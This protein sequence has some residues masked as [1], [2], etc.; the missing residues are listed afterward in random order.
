MLILTLHFKENF[1]V[2]KTHEKMIKLSIINELKVYL[3]KCLKNEDHPLEDDCQIF[4]LI[5]IFNLKKIHHTFDNWVMRRN[6]DFF[7][8]NIFI[9]KEKNY[10]LYQKEIE[11]E[12]NKTKKE[13]IF[14]NIV[15]NKL[16]SEK[17][18][19]F[20]Y[21]FHTDIFGFSATCL[22][23]KIYTVFTFDENEIRTYIQGGIIK[24]S[25]YL[26]YPPN[27]HFT[28]LLRFCIFNNN[29]SNIKIMKKIFSSIFENKPL[30]Q[31]YID[32]IMILY[33]ISVEDFFEN[34]FIF[35][36]NS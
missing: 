15:F 18:I 29:N 23:S 12:I 32:E 27:N 3:D 30:S 26:L 8:E 11:F 24:E 14:K 9:I 25:D 28:K 34:S 21:Y 31:Q 1:I 22:K 17:N 5:E 2:K 10:N 13:V 19:N 33:D 36:F 7:E 35:N 20:M 6:D 16:D 4:N